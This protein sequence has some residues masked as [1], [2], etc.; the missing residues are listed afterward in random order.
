REVN[1]VPE[2]ESVIIPDTFWVF[3]PQNLGIEHSVVFLIKSKQ[4]NNALL[5][6]QSCNK[7][8][9]GFTTQ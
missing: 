9:K 8:L 2:P 5:K 7:K 6:K 1:S 3:A 4:K